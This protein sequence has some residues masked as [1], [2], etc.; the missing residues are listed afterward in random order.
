MAPFRRTA[1]PSLGLCALNHG[2]LGLALPAVLALLPAPALRAAE[3][4]YPPET[5]FREVQ[6]RT[7]TCGR[8]N[9]AASC[10]QARRLADPLL[11]H[12]RLST[13][14]K[15]ALWSVRQRA[16]V[17]PLNSPE[18]RDPIDKASRDVIAYCRQ[19]YRADSSKPVEIPGGKP[20]SFKPVNP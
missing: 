6:L 18:R 15:D 7:L 16:V 1:R 2:L 19:P 8:D 9:T 14:C 12:P 20:F 3:A 17:A 10:D 4:P 11:D 13:S 5:S